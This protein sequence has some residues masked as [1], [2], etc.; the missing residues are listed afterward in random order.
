VTANSDSLSWRW[1]RTRGE[2]QQIALALMI[3]FMM[4]VLEEIG[5][6]TLQRVFSE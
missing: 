1:K 4:K 6:R 5:Y 2:Q 3:T